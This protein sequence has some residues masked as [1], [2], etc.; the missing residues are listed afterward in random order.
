MIRPSYTRAVLVGLGALLLTVTALTAQHVRP[1]QGNEGWAAVNRVTCRLTTAATTSTAITGCTAPGAGLS[2]YVTDISVYGGV[3]TGATAAASVQ[4]GTGGT[5]G[6]G[7]TVVY[8]CQHAATAGCEA[9][10]VTP[11][12]A[13]ANAELC[14]VDATVGTKFVNV[15]GYIAP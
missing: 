9:H 10:F 1:V 7:T 5:C 14:V 12:K 15:S 3:A 6:S 13:A 4:Y 8:D 11:R 2:L